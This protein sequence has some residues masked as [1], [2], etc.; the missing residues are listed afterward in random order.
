MRG[1]NALVVAC[2]L[3]VLVGA[4]P[5]AVTSSG[6]ASTTVVTVGDGATVTGEPG[7]TMTL[8]VRANATGVRGYQAN[9][10]F[11]PNVVEVE[12][13][14]RSE[15][16]EKPVSNVNNDEGWVSFNQIR[17]SETDDPVLATVT[18]TVTGASGD[19]TKLSFAEEDT[20]FADGN[21][22][23]F[24]SQMY[25]PL[26]VSVESSTPT[27]TATPTSTPT[28]TPTSTPTATPTST[29]TETPTATPTATPTSTPTETPTA[30]PT[31][32]PTSTPTATP[33]ATPTETSTPTD[34]PSPTPTP[35]DT[36]KDS[37]GD[38][39]GEDEANS[40]GSSGNDAN[41]GGGGGDD[42]N[43][44][45]GDDDDDDGGNA[46]GSVDSSSLSAGEP[47]LAVANVTLNTSSPVAGR[48]VTVSA[49]VENTGD[50]GG[51]FDTQV[52]VDENA[53]EANRTVAVE[54]GQ[55]REVNLSL[56]FES[57]GTYAVA[58]NDTAVGNVTVQE[59]N[60]PSASPPTTTATTDA[61]PT[62]DS[63]ATLTVE[64]GTSS[65]ATAT[66]ATEPESTERTA[67]SAPGFGF[68][69]TAGAIVS[70]AG[71]LRLRRG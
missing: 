51:E 27:P 25:D 8:T 1:R 58:V 59:A 32:T 18:L 50:A 36:P 13:V 37:G 9:L 34:T 42:V 66:T 65:S 35:T 24:S 54:A 56:R 67:E 16:F 71:W 21:G 70:L 23:T 62:S 64:E 2:A 61:T 40:G 4:L 28:A 15:D 46:G 69:V 19:S 60:T 52:Y 31:A 43:S 48:P 12:S 30:T 57:P 38:A 26:E 3:V 55:R 10:T 33:T 29:P 44:G 49:V 63:P 39:S 47:S 22:E 14:S 20:K 45:G 7:E 11:D 53:T 6:S 68:G 41:S 5:V 17:S